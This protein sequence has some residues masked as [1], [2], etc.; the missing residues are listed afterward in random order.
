SLYARRARHPLTENV[1]EGAAS[2]DMLGTNLSVKQSDGSWTT[3]SERLMLM[4]NRDFNRLGLGMDD[5]IEGYLQSVQA[6]IAIDRMAE[7]LVTQKGRFRR[8]FFRSVN[9]DDALIE[10]IC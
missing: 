3:E 9:P 10:D 4:D 6:T 7:R 5:L 8:K 2:W 1:E